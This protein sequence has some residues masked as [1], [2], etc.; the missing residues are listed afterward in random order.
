MG[1]IIKVSNADFSANAIGKYDF[2]DDVFRPF[3][4][5]GTP[6]KNSIYFSTYRAL[7][8]ESPSV[9][10]LNG[11]NMRIKLN[12]KHRLRTT[13]TQRIF[14]FSSNNTVVT[15]DVNTSDKLVMYIQNH[16]LGSNRIFT[17][18]NALTSSTSLVDGR[19][20]GADTRLVID[21]IYDAAIG[22]Y[23][24]GTCTINETELTGT[25]S[26]S[27][28]S[29]TTVNNSL[30]FNGGSFAALGTNTTLPGIACTWLASV[31][32]NGNSII[33]FDFIGKSETDMLTDKV[34][35]LVLQKYGAFLTLQ[36]SCLI[37]V[38]D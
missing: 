12:F 34:S 22:K 6:Q 21:L 27:T 18:T 5:D 14:S 37:E 30:L 17:T 3:R 26:N 25:K 23:D 7:G 20:V 31:I 2:N 10:T 38:G 11:K 16:T 8:I 13:D 35:G 24:F 36:D 28:V 1:T 33:H 19:L 15:I 32:E 4:A 9:S 29:I